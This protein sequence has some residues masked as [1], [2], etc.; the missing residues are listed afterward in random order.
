MTACRKLGFRS[1]GDG[2]CDNRPISRNANLVTVHLGALV[3]DSFRQSRRVTADS[4]WFFMALICAPVMQLFQF[5]AASAWT[6]GRGHVAVVLARLR[7]GHERRVS[8]CCR[9]SL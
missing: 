1:K 9:H 7:P 3:R 4:L 2:H 8:W 5:L 6:P